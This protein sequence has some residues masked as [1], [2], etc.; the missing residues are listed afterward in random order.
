M[1]KKLVVEGLKKSFNTGFEALNGIDMDADEGDVIAVIGPSG[2]GKSTLLRCLNMLETPTEGRIVVNGVELTSPRIDINKERRNIGMVFQQFNLF[3]HI[4]VKR[5]VTLAPIDLKHMD[6]HEADRQAMAL[7]K[8]VG[9]ADKASAYPRQLS[10]GQQQRAAIA[11]TLA[12]EPNLI[13]FDEPTSALDPEMI[14]EVLHVIRDL[15]HSGMTMI[16]VTHEMNFA[17][18][19]A[20]KVI[21]LENGLILEQGTPEQIF[22]NPKEARTRQFLSLIS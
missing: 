11:R 7:L 5:N 3:P 1:N 21:V 14:N 2:S 9:L 22:Q 15:A 18:D 6:K 10:G 17:R 13:L 8:R 20:N 4:N 12:M 16:I 19:I